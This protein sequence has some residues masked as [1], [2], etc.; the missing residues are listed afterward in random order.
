M[1]SPFKS[2]SCDCPGIEQAGGLIGQNGRI[3]GAIVDDHAI[4]ALVGIDDVFGAVAGEVGHGQLDGLVGLVVGLEGAV[5]VAEQHQDIAV[6]IADEQ[7][8]LAVARS[9]RRTV[10]PSDPTGT[11]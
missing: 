6:G 11:A 3:A 10:S 8:E 2:A 1:P 9:G 5:A 4:E 7:V